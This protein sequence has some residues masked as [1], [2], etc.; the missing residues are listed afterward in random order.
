MP[1]SPGRL[2]DAVGLFALASSIVLIPAETLRAQ[3]SV[4]TGGFTDSATSVGLRPTLSAAEIRTFLPDRGVFTFPSPYSTQG[5]RLTTSSDCAGA[6]CVLPVGYSYWS[7][8]NNHVGSDTMLIFLGLDR[9]KGGGGPTLFSFNKRT[10][11]TRNLGPIFPPDSPLSWS[12]G[13]GW[14]FSATQPMMLYMNYG[15]RMLRS[16]AARFRPLPLCSARCSI[17]RMRCLS[18]RDTCRLDGRI[19]W[20]QS[21]GFSYLRPYSLSNLS[22]NE[23]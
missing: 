23:R 20:D 11:E 22:K 17:C 19:F 3:V 8:A 4:A 7:N 10:G 6:D 15:P 21:S 1:F 5:V 12:T 13:E 9:R 16:S 14:Y 18:R 2:V